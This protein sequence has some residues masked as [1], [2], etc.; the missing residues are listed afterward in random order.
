MNEFVEIS[1]NSDKIC[2]VPSVV[3]E[4]PS[5]KKGQLIYASGGSCFGHDFSRVRIHKDA[6]VARSAR[7]VNSVGYKVMA[8]IVE[9]G[10]YSPAKEK[11]RK[12]LA[13]ELANTTQ[14]HRVLYRSTSSHE[15]REV[16]TPE[17]LAKKIR[18]AFRGVGTDEEEVYRILQFP[19]PMVRT[20]INYYNEHYN[21]HTGKGFLEDVKDEFSSDELDKVYRLLDEANVNKNEVYETKRIQPKVTGETGRVWVGLIVRGKY[22]KEHHP[23]VMEQHADVVVPSA[24]GEMPTMGYFGQGGGVSGGIGLGM[25]GISADLPWF[26]ANRPQYVD[27]ELAKL[28]D[29]RSS[30]ILIKVTEKQATILTKYWADLKSDPGTF[31]IL[32][33]NCS[34]AAAAGFEK[35][36][37][38]KEIS[39]LD[40]P[41]NLF[42]QLR[43]QYKDAYMISGYYGYT[44]IGRNWQFI[45]SKLRLVNEG[46]GPWAGPFVAEKKLK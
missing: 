7:E 24:S 5:S 36:R 30:L 8:D 38:T 45:G 19:G 2:R 42:E 44:R 37:I 6:E 4:A 27:L 40:T 22:S 32:G 17:V 9:Q 23:G 14:E 1:N 25:E 41:D 21:D 12:L 28:V 33:A 46:A 31:N 15:K 35:A 13:H 43:G 16:E 26:L 29:M 20:M 10:Q 11:R 18:K 3:K 34:T 39:G